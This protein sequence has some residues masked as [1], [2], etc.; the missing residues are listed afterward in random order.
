MTEQQEISMVEHGERVMEA[1]S[2]HVPYQE[3]LMDVVDFIQRLETASAQVREL[4]A[5]REH[6]QAQYEAALADVRQQDTADDRWRTLA[7]RLA[8]EMTWIE[9][10]ASRSHNVHCDVIR[11]KA[12]AALA[13]FEAAKE[14][15]DA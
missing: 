4:T 11:V 8:G 13:D 10:E 7:E 14:D 12:H 6:W 3:W 9:N 15:R 5:E 2:R 1:I